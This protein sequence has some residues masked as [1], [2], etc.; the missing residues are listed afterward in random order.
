MNNK[1]L[2]AIHCL[3]YNHEPYLKDCLDGFVAQQTDFP[4]VAIVQDDAS[5]DMSADILREYTDKY[6]DIIKPIYHTENLWSKGLVE[7]DIY[8]AIQATGCKYIAICEGDDY[9]TDPL[10][11]Q[12]QVD[13]LEADDSLIGVF[14][15]NC[16]VDAEGNILKEKNDNLVPDRTKTR[17][18]LRDFFRYNPA[19]PTASVM[20]RNNHQKEKGPMYEHTKNPFLGDWTSWIILHIFGD[21]YYLDDVT[22]AYRQN[23]TSLT[24]TLNRVERAKATWDICASVADILPQEYDDI[25]RHLRDRSWNYIYVAHAYR[26]EH[27]YLYAAY[28]FLVS[29]IKA[30]R[31]TIKYIIRYLSKYFHK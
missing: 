1:P 30:P 23:P 15:N 16:V 12:K 7:R 14:T 22:S 4:F 28:Y 13:I 10:K 5:T 18:T 6:P 29:C 8:A 27:Q 21:F 2:V 24:H 26:K 9:W 20:Y 19:Y 31:K 3:V 17:Y 25:I 11:L